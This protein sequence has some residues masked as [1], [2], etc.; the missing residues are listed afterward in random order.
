MRDYVRVLRLAD[1]LV[2]SRDLLTPL[3]QEGGG[4]P[5]LL[6]TLYSIQYRL[7]NRDAANAVLQQVH[8]E[9]RLSRGPPRAGQQPLRGHLLSEA[10]ET[11]TRV[12]EIDPN[13]AVALYNLGTI[14]LTA[15]SITPTRNLHH[16]RARPGPDLAKARLNLGNVCFRT[17]RFEEARQ[18]YEEVRRRQPHNA[19]VLNNLGLLERRSY[20]QS[21]DAAALQRAQ[22]S[23]RKPTR[24]TLASSTPWLNQALLLPAKDNSRALGF[25]P[26]DPELRARGAPGGFPGTCLYPPGAGRLR[27]R[28]TDLPAGGA[29]QPVR[30]R[31]KPRAQRPW[32][33]PCSKQGRFDEALEQ[34]DAVVAQEGDRTRPR[35]PTAP[36]SSCPATAPCRRP[37]SCS[38]TPSSWRT[39][40]R[41]TPTWPDWNSSPATSPPRWRRTD[42][43]GIMN[44]CAACITTRHSHWSAPVRMREGGS[45]L[46]PG[47]ARQS[48][49]PGCSPQPGAGISWTRS[50]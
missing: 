3:M 24:R 36:W 40:P 23:S 29:G 2:E 41:P 21:G 33:S 50:G 32:P 27:R 4:D 10:V 44:S 45:R 17:G 5:N 34:L 7:G 49:L 13:N 6:M 42:A 18:E 14:G 16:R 25:G 48:R 43:Q 28:G 8:P 12:L 11:Y 22:R 39:W 37:A 38:P 9:P 46:S 35:P 1:K 31:Q 19:I 26:R 15:A 30:C 20:Q 47:A